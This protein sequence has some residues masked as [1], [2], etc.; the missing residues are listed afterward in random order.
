MAHALVRAAS[1]PIS[2]QLFD[3]VGAR[4]QVADDEKRSSAPPFAYVRIAATSRAR[5]KGLLGMD[6]LEPG[7]ALWIAPCEA[8]HTFGMKFPID[9]VFL[10]KNGKVKKIVPRLKPWRIAACLTAS[11]VL[12][13]EAGAAERA[14]LRVGARLRFEKA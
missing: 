8:V 2:T 6:R 5:R 4:E 13:L 1:R 9:V 10:G 7:A 3:P 14:Q 12:E 11:S